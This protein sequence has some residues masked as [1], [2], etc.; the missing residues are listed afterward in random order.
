M[1]AT[2][3]APSVA[4]TPLFLAWLGLVLLTLLGLALGQWTDHA[5][6]LQLPVAAIVWLK[7]W[8]VARHFIEA[9]LAHPF[10][11]RVVQ[12]F[13]ACVPFA[14]VLTAWLGERFVRMTTL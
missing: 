13:I 5:A 8:V 14:L 4:I 10:I 2:R 1:K 9:H 3:T 11:A 6:W 12:G 7:G